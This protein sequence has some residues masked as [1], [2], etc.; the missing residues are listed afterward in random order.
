MSEKWRNAKRFYCMVCEWF[1]FEECEQSSFVRKL[2]CAANVFWV[3][4]LFTD[5]PRI[6]LKQKTSLSLSGSRFLNLFRV[7]S[8]LFFERVVI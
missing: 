3:L 6:S 7:S 4:T 5:K 1:L 2:L 8:V